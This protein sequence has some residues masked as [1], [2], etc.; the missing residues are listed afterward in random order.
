MAR[1]ILSGTLIAL[2][3]IL[4]VLSIVGMAAVWMY[5]QPLTDQVLTQ[6]KEVDTELAQAQ[7]A[8]Q[9]AKIELERTLRIVEAAE[10]TLAA[11]KDELAQAKLLFGEVN[12][13]LDQQLIPALQSSRAKIDQVKIALVDLRASLEKINAI[14]FIEFKLPGDEMLANLIGVAASTDAEIARVENLVQK[15]STFVSDASYLMGGDLTETKRNLNEFLSVVNAYDQKITAWRVQVAT[16]LN[17][18]PGWINNTAVILT[19]FLLWFGFSQFGLFLHGLE[20][21]SGGNPL[22]TLREFRSKDEPPV[23]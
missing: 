14:P 22:A 15:A 6:L 23:V 11:L 2:S 10:Q 5:K 18:M 16:L 3:S 7:S 1:K 13:T 19:I 21:W 20:A 4:L 17:S 12:G 8:L 9:N